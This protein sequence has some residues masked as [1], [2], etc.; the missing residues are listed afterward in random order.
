MSTPR[1]RTSVAAFAQDLNH[2]HW[3]L[4]LPHGDVL[5]AETNAPPRPQHAKGLKGWVMKLVMKRAGAGV[6]SANRITLL[7]DADGDG[8]A[9]VRE[10]FAAGLNSPFGMALVAAPEGL[11]LY[12]ANTDALL[13][14]A[15]RPGQTKLDAPLRTVA[16]LPAGER[17]HHWTKSLIASPDGSKLYVGVGSNSNVAENGMPAEEGRAAVWLIDRVSGAARIFADG[18]R[19]PVGLAWSPSIQAGDSAPR[20]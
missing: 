3:L 15:Y 6:P 7:R 17:N 9:E 14:F 5:V 13:E 8:V 10:V 1:P 20:L 19:N 4:A 12:V 18:L 2:P 11:R 16:A